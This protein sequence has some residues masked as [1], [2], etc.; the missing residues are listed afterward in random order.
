MTNEKFYQKLL[1][2]YLINKVKSN[3]DIIDTLRAMVCEIYTEDY[4]NKTRT[5][6]KKYIKAIKK[7]EKEN[8]NNR[9]YIRKLNV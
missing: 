7:L 6:T 9:K 4:I 3:I 1:L 8:E 2:E 5:S